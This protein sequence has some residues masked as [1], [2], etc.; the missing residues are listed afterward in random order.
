MV[1]NNCADL[2]FNRPFTDAS[3][4]RIEFRG[5][6]KGN[7]PT[8]THR[9]TTHMCTHHKYLPCLIL[10]HP[11]SLIAAEKT[12]WHV[13]RFIQKSF[14]VYVMC[15]QG[16]SPIRSVVTHHN[17]HIHTQVLAF[18]PLHVSSYHCLCCFLFCPCFMC[19]FL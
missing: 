17:T 16:I 3:E 6:Q 11:Q 10:T 5:C 9:H 4:W 7:S 12:R 1:T 14:P 8:N 15:F 18:G 2:V 13:A 19:V